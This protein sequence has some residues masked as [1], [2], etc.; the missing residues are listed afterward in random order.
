M[1]DPFPDWLL[2]FLTLGAGLVWAF[3]KAFLKEAQNANQK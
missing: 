2:L 1:T 3:N